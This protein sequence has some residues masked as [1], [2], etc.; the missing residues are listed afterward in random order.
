LD[1]VKYAFPKAI[2]KEGKFNLVFELYESVKG[3]SRI[4]EYLASE[5]RQKY[6][7]G[8]YKYSAELDEG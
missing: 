6:G 5:R 8:I 7:M 3:R 2:G 1:A 4:K